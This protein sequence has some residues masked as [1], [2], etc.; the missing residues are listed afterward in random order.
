MTSANPT[1]LE[2]SHSAPT[3]LRVGAAFFGAIG[4]F[5]FALW[6]LTKWHWTSAIAFVFCAAGFFLFVISFV[7]EE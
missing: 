3:G 5:F 7:P 6:L 4:G 2:N 1:G